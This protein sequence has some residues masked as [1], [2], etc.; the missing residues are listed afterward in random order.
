ML[1]QTYKLQQT[2]AHHSVFLLQSAVTSPASHLCTCAR[3]DSSSAPA[4]RYKVDFA[5]K[6]AESDKVAVIQKFG[7]FAMTAEYIHIVTYISI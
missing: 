6:A 5:S 7:A 3:F 4:G 2:T 1:A